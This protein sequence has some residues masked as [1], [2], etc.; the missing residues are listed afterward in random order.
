M[1][2]SKKDKKEL[3]NLL[4][5]LVRGYKGMK[6]DDLILARPRAKRPTVIN[7]YNEKNELIRTE[8]NPP[9]YGPREFVNREGEIIFP[10]MKEGSDLEFIANGIT[11]LRN[12]L[13]EDESVIYRG[14]LSEA[15][16][17]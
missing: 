9:N 13:N 11:A 5:Q 7:I 8:P 10:I 15:Q 12:L 14:P 1:K 17:W 4:A 6:Q 16:K 3:E 2:L